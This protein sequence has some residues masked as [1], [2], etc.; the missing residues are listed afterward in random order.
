MPRGSVPQKMQQVVTFL[1]G[2]R[3]R[4]IRQALAAHGLSREEIEAGWRLVMELE[5]D[6]RFDEGPTSGPILTDLDAWENLWLPIADATLNARMPAVHAEVFKNLRQTSG[7]EVVIGVRTFLERLDALAR[8]D[9]PTRRAA[10]ELLRARGLTD[11]VLDEARALIARI[12]QAESAPA[13]P[14]I[15]T[16]AQE[17]AMWR[18]YKEWS[19]VARVV[20]TDRRHLNA[21][22][23]SRTKPGADPAR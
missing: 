21:L 19:A 15:C 2:L 1:I 4:P 18:W 12:E 14:P 6:G 8:S 17:E 5:D 7:L 11:A 9:D 13:S 3:H 10:R 22:G 16:E 23:F 20:L